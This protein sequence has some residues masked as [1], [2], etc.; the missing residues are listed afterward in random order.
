MMLVENHLFSAAAVW[1]AERVSSGLQS[2]TYWELFCFTDCWRW[3]RPNTAIV[4]A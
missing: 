2:P 3:P 1:S 4:A